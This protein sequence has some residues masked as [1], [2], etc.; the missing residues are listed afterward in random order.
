MAEVMSESGSGEA[1]LQLPAQVTIARTSLG[2]PFG[3]GS[4]DAG[5]LK[6]SLVNGTAVTQTITRVFP[7]PLADAQTGLA[8]RTAGTAL[9]AR[10]D[11]SSLDPG[12]ATTIEITGTVPAHP[13]TYT[14][15]LEV[16]TEAG[17]T[18]V[19]PVAIAVAANPGWGV[20]CMLLGLLLLGVLKLLTGEGD[21]QEKAREVLRAR[22]KIHS[23]LQRDPPPQRRVEAVAEIDRNLD[24][25][26]R[27][28]AGPHRFSVVDRRIRDADAALSA[29]RDGYAKLRDALS[30]T[31]PGTAEVADVTEDWGGL[32][33]RMR[34][35]ATL[36]NPAA[37]P[38][39]GLAGHAAILLH[40]VWERVIGLPLQW[41]AADLGP[42]LERVRLAQAAG[43]TDRARAMALAT[44]AWLRRAADDLD[45]RLAMMMGLNLIAGRMVVSDAWVRRLAAGDELT[46]ENAAPCSTDSPRQMRA[47][48]RE[49]PLRTCPRLRAPSR[50]P[51]PRPTAIAPRPS[52]PAC[53]PSPMPLPRR[54]PPS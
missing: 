50:T 17:E 39:T 51:K 32:Q 12:E 22:A 13:G 42:Q 38:V 43:E 19:A 10:V 54:C 2:G 27:T 6:V 18:A 21:V 49:R 15:R 16:I 52:R 28:L 40:R 48:L 24:E 45:R 14:A 53:R 25:A 30:K 1:G 46:P 29:A 20:A 11:K 41:V 35:L 33:E 36:D 4:L 3:R 7:A 34:S 23:L 47:S 8:L 5:R 26:V 44:R 37:A 31:P 9:S